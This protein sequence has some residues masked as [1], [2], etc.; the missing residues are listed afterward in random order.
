MEKRRTYK[1]EEKANIVLQLL[2]E[3]R[4]MSQIA[5]ETGI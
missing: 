4:T 1:A 2:R 3:E 5:A